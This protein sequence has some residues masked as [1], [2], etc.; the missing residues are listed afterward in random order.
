M[1]RIYV[2]TCSWSDHTDFYPPGLPSNQQLSFYAQHFS[3]VEID[4]TFYTM[5]PAR[6]YQL[7]AQR[8]PPEFVFDV[9]PYRQLTWHDRKSPPDDEITQRFRDSLEPLRQAGKLSALNFQFPPWFVYRKENLE[10]LRRC[11]D[12]FPNDRLSVEFRHRSW[13]EEARVD[14]VVGVLRDLRVGLTVVDEPQIGSGSV[15]TVLEVTRPDLALVRFHG[16]NAK[17]WYAKVKRT[18][19]RFDY[20]YSEEEL[21]DWIPNIAHLAERADELHLLFNNNRDNFAVLNAQ[22]LQMILQNSMP[23]SKVVRVTSP[24]P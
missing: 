9:K 13:L 10:Y 22:Q 19:E 4:A 17:M 7:W 18:G 3:V 2:G 23:G 14:E 24:E 20:L 6:N 5:M 21:R 11:R 1:S 16:R 12:N 8:T 15:P